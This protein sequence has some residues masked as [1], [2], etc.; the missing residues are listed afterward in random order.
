MSVF[1][2]DTGAAQ[3]RNDAYP[4]PH[5]PAAE[6]DLRSKLR[7]LESENARLERFS[8]IA[9]HEVAAPLRVIAGY[10][11]LLL[12]G[13]AGQL[14][15]EQADFAARI[16][17]S[18]ERMQRLL[19]DLRRRARTSATFNPVEVDLGELLEHVRA[20]L[21]PAL[22]EREAQLLATTE[23][24]VVWGDP[25]QLGQLLANLIG[26]AVK[27]GPPRGGSVELSAQR[28]EG[29]WLIAVRDHGIGVDAADQERIFE[30]FARGAGTGVPGSGLGLAVCREVVDTHGGTLTVDSRPGA[31]ATFS[32]TLP[33]RTAAA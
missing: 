7:E 27:F 12:D 31:G 9:A 30:P 20:D 10:A 13:S 5:A 6:V 2:A 18:A 19:D 21:A 29:G 14:S 23:L 33:D 3:A 4:V 16:A 8:A 28:L 17:T 1:D 22:E 24:P 15:R 25:I 32:F 26:N 11:A